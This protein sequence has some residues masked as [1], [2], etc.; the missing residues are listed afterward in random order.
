MDAR[1]A[2]V[3]HLGEDQGGHVADQM[4]DAMGRHLDAAVFHGTT[5]PIQEN[6]MKAEQI[7]TLSAT[8][9]AELT[10]GDL[11]GMSEAERLALVV[12]AAYGKALAERDKAR[13][14]VDHLH[15]LL[16]SARAL[17]GRAQHSLGDS[18]WAADASLAEQIG[19]LMERM[20]VDSIQQN[21]TQGD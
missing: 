3:L 2:L 11:D 16:G 18:S 20:D 10:Q 15:A 17:L 13:D 19:Q 7:T 6:E 14:R 5:P 21:N 12:G 9:D 4:A 8:V 1:Q